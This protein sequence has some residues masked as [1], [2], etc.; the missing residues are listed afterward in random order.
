ML[1]ERSEALQV[2]VFSG[3]DYTVLGVLGMLG[4][5]PA[6]TEGVGFGSYLI[7]ELWEDPAS[8][9]R[10]VRIR[11]NLKPFY[12]SVAGTAVADRVQHENERVMDAMDGAQ[13]QLLLQTL[14]TLQTKKG[15]LRQGTRGAEE[16]A[17]EDNG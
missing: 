6:V 3:H 14:E 5:I 4:A 13:A 7:L 9:R 1:R 11:Y 16:H 17:N 15:L 8:A 12:D 2:S 10:V